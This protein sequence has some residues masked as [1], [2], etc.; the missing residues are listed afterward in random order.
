MSARAIILAAGLSRR[1]R[2]LTGERPKSFLEVGGE[3]LLQRHLRLLRAAGVE[4]ITLVVGYR[5]ELFRAAC[6]GCRF[7]NNARYASTNTAFSLEL[8]LR[9]EERKPVLV[10]NGDVYCDAPVLGDV[11]AAPGGTLAA[12]KRHPLSAE[13]VKVTVDGRQITAIGKQLDPAGAYGEAFGVYRLAPAFAIALRQ[14]LRAL[15]GADLY[16]EHGMDRLLDAGASMGLHDVG[17]APV[18][19]LDFPQDYHDLLARLG[20]EAPGA[21]SRAPRAASPP[22]VA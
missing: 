8:A 17:A 16:Y 14:A 4:D 21:P 19:E 22:R 10:I 9:A 20:A 18:V 6:P 11:L 2:P 5:A 7:V 12:V 15:P 1:M 3:T 13:E